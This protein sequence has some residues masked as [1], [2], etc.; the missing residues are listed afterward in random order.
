MKHNKKKKSTKTQILLSLSKLWKCQRVKE[1]TILF[2]NNEAQT[3][4][5]ENS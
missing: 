3:K 5:S 4:D 2:L 1:K